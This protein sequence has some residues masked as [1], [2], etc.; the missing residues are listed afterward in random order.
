MC[1]G[2]Q[3]DICGIAPLDDQTFAKERL[4]FR[5]AKTY[6]PACHQRFYNRLYG[7]VAIFVLLALILTLADRW[8]RADPFSLSTLPFGLLLIVLQYLLV[9]P[10][11]L[12]HAIA[13][14]LGGFSDIRILLGSGKSLFHFKALGFTWFINVVPAGGLTWAHPPANAARRHHI[15]FTASGLLVNA[16]LLL[17]GLTLPHILDLSSSGNLLR[18]LNWANAIVIIE[19]LLPYY[20]RTPFGMIPNDGKALCELIFRWGKPAPPACRVSRT[21]IWAGRLLKGVGVTILVLCALGLLAIAGMLGSAN[22]T[23]IAIVFLLFFVALSALLF[24]Y[25]WRLL[26]E[27]LTAGDPPVASDP[28]RWLRDLRHKFPSPLPL[29]EQASIEGWIAH[30]QPEQAIA[31]CERLLIS[32]PGDPTLLALHGLALAETSPARAASIWTNLKSRIPSA[33]VEIHAAIVLQELAIHIRHAE[34]TDFIRACDNFLSLNIPPS[35]K[36]G[37]LDQ[38]ACLVL[39][40][41]LSPSLASAEF[42]VRRALDLA[43]GNLTLQGTLGAIL[44]E[45]GNTAEAEPLLHE[46]FDRSPAMHDQAISGF[47]LAVIAARRNET[48]RAQALAR[49]SL[50]L[51]PQPWLLRKAE[52]HLRHQPAE[53]STR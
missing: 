39:Y 15:V 23:P 48:K 32:N 46:C 28:Y 30:H 31:V 25:A 52:V 33:E 19:N 47:Y 27:P 42:C 11:E 14:R 4:P 41:D 13:A 53:A 3:C 26:K 51:Y 12:G 44:T 16:V 34:P 17:I 2:L 35:E 29:S 6:C 37:F 43:P 36:I 40:D 45:L 22:I 8:Q 49:K 7:G 1:I 5:R 50:A 21:A 10:H 38:L 20:A 24:W 18:A 9:I